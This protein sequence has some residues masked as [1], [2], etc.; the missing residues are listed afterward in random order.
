MTDLIFTCS[1][2]TLSSFLALNGY[3]TYRYRY[4]ASFLSTSIF[5]NSGAYHTSE[6]PEVF[7]TYP[8]S[9]QF[10]SVTTQQIELSSFMQKTWASFANDPS[11]GV[12]W[13]KVGSAF[14]KELGLLGSNG[15]SGVNVVNTL[16]ADYPC[17][18]LEPIGTALKF[19]Y[20]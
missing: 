2:G 20:R 14:G 15:G 17:L 16:V 18:V 8:V 9:N 5:A 11:G 12:G 1:T 3:T 10:G 6:I 7:G 13:P 19:N 4:D